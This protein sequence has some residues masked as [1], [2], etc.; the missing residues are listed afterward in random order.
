MEPV[1]RRARAP[2]EPGVQAEVAGRPASVLDALDVLDPVRLPGLA[3]VLGERLLPAARVRLDVVPEVAHQDRLAVPDLV[4]VERAGA[5]LA[6]ERADGGRQRQPAQSV[7][8]PVDA[9]LAGLL[10]VEAD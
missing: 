9:P 6:V 1:G 5:V 7:R 4:V 3:A 2:Q 10:V 8:G